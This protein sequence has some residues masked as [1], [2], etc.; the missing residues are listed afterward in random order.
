MREAKKVE[1]REGLKELEKWRST[2]K[3]PLTL[4]SP[5]SKVK[6]GAEAKKKDSDKMDTS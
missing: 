4:K 3:A 5:K 6:L 2:T 1:V